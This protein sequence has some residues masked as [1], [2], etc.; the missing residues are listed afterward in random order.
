[1]PNSQLP[2]TSWGSRNHSS[3][4]QPDR[5][6]NNPQL[7]RGSTHSPTDLGPLTREQMAQFAQVMGTNG[8]R[9]YDAARNLSRDLQKQCTALP[10]RLYR[11]PS[12][13]SA[14]ASF[15]FQPVLLAVVIPTAL[16]SCQRLPR[17]HAPTSSAPL[18]V[19]SEMSPAGT[20]SLAPLVLR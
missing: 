9:E 18:A 14:I 7:P 20:S 11:P 2:S 15:A 4:Q 5:K 10:P 17:A 8:F 13:S 3:G 16:T 6:P 1:M 12:S 19:S